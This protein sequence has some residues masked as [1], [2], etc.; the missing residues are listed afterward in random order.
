MTLSAVIDRE[1]YAVG[2]GVTITATFTDNGVPIAGGRSR[3]RSSI[4][5]ARRRRWCSR[6][7]P[8]PNEL[9]AWYSGIFNDTAEA[10]VSAVGGLAEAIGSEVHTAATTSPSSWQP[11]ALSGTFADRGVDTDGDGLFNQLV[12]TSRSPWTSPRRLACVA[13]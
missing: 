12:V 5:A 1:R 11:P 8:P 13:R 6:A 3:H 2:D 10:G 7:P 9:Q 4:P